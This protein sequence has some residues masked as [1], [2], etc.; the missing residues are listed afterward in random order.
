MFAKNIP[1]PNND[2][3]YDEGPTSKRSKGKKKTQLVG[4]TMFVEV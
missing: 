2:N 4:D 1:P 3:N